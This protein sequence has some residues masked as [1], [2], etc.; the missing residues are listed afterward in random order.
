MN[1]T[2]RGVE[3]DYGLGPVLRGISLEVPES[4]FLVVIG[5]N[6]AGKSTLLRIAAGL[7]RPKAGEVLLGSD[8]V[9]PLS[10]VEIARR[11]ALVPQESAMSLPFRVIEAVLM[12]RHPYLGAW[13]LESGADRARAREALERVGL[14]GFE[15]RRF[16][17]LSGGEKQ[18]VVLARA[19]AQQ[20]PLLLLDEPTA[21][22]DLRHQAAIYDI[23]ADLNAAGATI[24]AVTHDLN[25]AGVYCRRVLAMLDGRARACGAPLEIL[26]R[27]LLEEVYGARLEAIPRGGGGPPLFVPAGRRGEPNH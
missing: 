27:D 21:F 18:R 11:V 6:G 16:H 12:G 14:G 25:L 8:P 7:L 9:A 26:R 2:L 3:H 1:L 17:E 4:D 15:Q 13:Q 24:V 23:L 19:I 10:R 5:A 20:A 22:L